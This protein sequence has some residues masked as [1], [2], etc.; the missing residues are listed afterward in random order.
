MEEKE[1]INKNE[2]KAKGSYLAG[3]AG[4]IIGGAIGAI[5]WILVYIYGNMLLSLLAV[6]IAAGEFYGYKLLKGKMTK[7]TPAIIMII[8]ILIVSAATLVVIPA[9]S[10]G[11]E[12]INVNVNTIKALYQDKA[13]IGGITHD[14]AISVVFTI[15]GASIITAN[16]KRSIQ[17]SVDGEIDLSNEDE[18]AKVKKDSI[19]KIKPIFEK[20]NSLDK[21]HGITKDELFAEFDNKDDLK[22]A[23]NYLKSF[24]IV[25]TSKGKLY[26]S[27][28]NE[29]KQ[30]KPKDN[31]MSKRI[32]VVVALIAVAAV[33]VMA[34]TKMATGN[35]TKEISDGKVSFK[36]SESWTSYT[37]SYVDGW[38]YYRYINTVPPLETNK[39]KPSTTSYD[40]Y[41]AYLNISN[42]EVDTTKLSKIE[43]VQS[44]MKDYIDTLETKPDAHEET[45]SK[46]KNGYDMLTMRMYFKE[47]PEQIEYLFY[48]LNGESMVCV[49][50]YSFNMD[51]EKEI[52]KNAEKI[53]DSLKWQE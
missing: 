29:E 31:K 53:I 23:F 35:K 51:D 41:P 34:C 8:A 38:N 6:L 10:L 46:T 47:G 16:V 2:T 25:K 22:I 15:L 37:N 36:I 1:V 28:E 26:Y 12:G 3:I 52:K 20:F 30:T 9:I 40:K 19:E 27:V 21:D 45:I 39:I 14:F 13:F 18:I 32:A 43:D 49:D 50:T 33:V 44:S 17:N 48:V 11:N 24:G 5:P 7:L 42:Y 4:A